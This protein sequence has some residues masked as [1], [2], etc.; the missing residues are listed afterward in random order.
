MIKQSGTIFADQDFWSQFQMLL[1][2]N[3][4]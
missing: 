2:A 4:M 3:Y 1:Q